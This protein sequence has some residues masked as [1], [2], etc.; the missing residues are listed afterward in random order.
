MK[1]ISS[2]RLLN[3]FPCIFPYSAN[4]FYSAVP[5]IF[6][7]TPITGSVPLHLTSTLLDYHVLFHLIFFLMSIYSSYVCVQD[8]PVF[9]ASYITTS[10][11][12][13]KLWISMLE[14]KFLC[15]F[16][17]NSS[18]FDF[19]IFNNDKNAL[20]AA[21]IRHFTSIVPVY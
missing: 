14:R 18:Q 4:L 5:C 20:S 1:G 11:P 8:I 17:C 13:Y 19:M 2:H 6:L 3:L 21:T 12:L 16:P 7:A 15:E 10:M 9:G